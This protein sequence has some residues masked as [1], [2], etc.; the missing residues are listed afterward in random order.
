MPF[1]FFRNARKLLYKANPTRMIIKIYSS[2]TT[3]IFVK[4]CTSMSEAGEA[5]LLYEAFII[6]KTVMLSLLIPEMNVNEAKFNAPNI[7]M[8]PKR[9]MEDKAMICSSEGFLG[10][11]FYF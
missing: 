3:K 2:F 1:L 9:S 7:I 6:L 5:N 8:K 11:F 10:S 4:K